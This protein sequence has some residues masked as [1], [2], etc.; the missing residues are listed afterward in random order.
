MGFEFFIAKRYLASKKTNKFI[1]V[2]TLFS[3]AGVLIGVAAL[4]IVLSMMNGFEKEIRSRIIGTTAHITVFPLHG[5]GLENYQELVPKI[6]EVKEVLAVS[7]YIYSKVA[8]ASQSQTDGIVLRGIEPA[9]EEKVTSISENIIEGNFDLNTEAGTGKV[10][11]G[12]YL[13]DNLE[14]KTGDQ[15]IIFSLKNRE[16]EAF[17]SSP[18]ATKFVVSGIFET[19]MYEYDG[20]L[21]YISLEKAQ[22]L[23]N[24]ENQVTG[25]E[26][27]IKKYFEAQK[28][29]QVI[30]KNL[31]QNFYVTD[32]MH[33][34]KNLFSW[35]SLEK[36]AMFIAL[37][38]IVAV[39][40]FAIISTLVI[41]VMEK[42][43][44][45]GILKS[46]GATSRN[47]MKIFVWKGTVIG[48]IG[49]LLGLS[50]G[51]LVCWVQQTFKII[52][53][54][55]EIYFISSLPMDMRI[56]DFIFVSAAALGITFLSSLY[57]AKKAS[58]L[59]PVEAIRY[60]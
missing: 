20:G 30:E 2:I 8:I 6:L 5:E 27:K 31:G 19:G 35:M 60:E 18:R 11:L 28:I 1:S 26:V 22:A 24:L 52:S 16:A 59:A 34:H 37:S 3:I 54:P 55:R 51:F 9:Q 39:A 43:K 44:D 15:V 58:S 38:L 49:T 57:P 14:V 17:S 36:Y 56:L 4:V 7:P 45:I 40:A 13:A 32:W 25:L 29:A 41:I 12:S 53:L 33:M 50:I 47:I 48:A 46:L 42:R 21:A 10:I 23:M